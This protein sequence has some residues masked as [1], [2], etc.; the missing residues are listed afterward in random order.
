[1][2]DPSPTPV[3][4]AARPYLAAVDR[5]PRG[6]GRFDLTSFFAAPGALQAFVA[7]LLVHFAAALPGVDA[8]VG[9]DALGF[10]LAGALG[11][12]ADRPVVLM[13]KR[14]KLALADDEKVGTGAFSDYAAAREGDK[15]F[16]VRRDLLKPGMSVIVVDE[17]ID[18]GAQMTA[19]C[20][21]LEA[22]D[23]RV[24]GIGTLQLKEGKHAAADALWERYDVFAA[25]RS[26]VV[27]TE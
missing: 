26:P 12:A 24:A 15:A 13:R 9:L 25:N 18:S 17:W 16:E 8:V 10:V 11:A 27:R 7:D 1:M 6:L 5:T 20:C 22:H 14:G 21:L 23:V 19:V 2:A 4:F 3:P